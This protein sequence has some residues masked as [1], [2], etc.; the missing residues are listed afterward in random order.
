MIY[1]G[2]LCFIHENSV[3]RTKLN[4]KSF[5]C[6]FLGQ[7]R[8][9]KRYKCH[10][11]TLHKFVIFEY[12]TIFECTPYFTKKSSASPSLATK[13]DNSS[14]PY[15]NADPMPHGSEIS[16]YRTCKSTTN[17][18]IVHVSPITNTISSELAIFLLLLILILNPIL[19]FLLST[20]QKNEVYYPSITQC[21]SFQLI[22]CFVFFIYSHQVPKFI[23][24]AMWLVGNYKVVM[25]DLKQN[26]IW[27]QFP[28]QLERKQLDIS[29]KLKPNGILAHLKVRL[30]AKG[31]KHMT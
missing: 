25:Q 23:S 7:S 6:V 2:Y 4:P 3:H 13:E 27:I 20:V 26:E 31:H 19:I 11:P 28:S 15:F 8:C 22:Q 30:V 10:C 1:F 12:V 17:A 24:D 14:S 9:Q 29:V 18:P 5:K 21:T 16:V